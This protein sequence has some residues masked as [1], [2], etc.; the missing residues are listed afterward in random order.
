[1]YD[2][3]NSTQVVCVQ[4]AMAALEARAGNVSAA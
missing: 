1:V 2:L 4:S 3:V